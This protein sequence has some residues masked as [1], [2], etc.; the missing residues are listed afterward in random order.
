MS[1]SRTGALAPYLPASTQC[2]DGELVLV[3]PRDAIA[4]S[5]HIRD[6]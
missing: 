2:G 5:S 4:N 3:Y 1:S 6:L